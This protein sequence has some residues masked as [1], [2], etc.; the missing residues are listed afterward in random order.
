MTTSTDTFETVQHFDQSVYMHVA[1]ARHMLAEQA[2]GISGPRCYVMQSEPGAVHL[3]ADYTIE[4]FPAGPGTARNEG[5]FYDNE[6][7]HRRIYAA[8]GDFPCCGYRLCHTCLGK[9]TIYRSGSS[10]DVC[11][12]CAGTGMTTL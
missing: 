11:G 6:G 12:A 5:V 4:S 8:A 2:A 10:F 3:A 1:L 7:M 9:G